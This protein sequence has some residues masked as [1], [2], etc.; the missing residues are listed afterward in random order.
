MEKKLELKVTPRLLS[1]MS[2][3]ASLGMNMTQIYQY[4]GLTKEE[5]FELRNQHPE[6][7]TAINRGKTKQL[8]SVSAKLMERVAQGD[9]KAIQFYLSA[10]GWGKYANEAYKENE[11]EE[12]SDFKMSSTDPVEAARIYQ[13]FIKR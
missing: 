6:I 4:Y 11:L 8:A 13:D 7:H 9:I 5:F 1:E 10:Q 3:L 2:N 12:I